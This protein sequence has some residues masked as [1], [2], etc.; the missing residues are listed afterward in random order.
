MNILFD[1]QAFEMQRFGGVSRSYAELI[2][3]LRK[4][5]CACKVGVKES[6]NVYLREKGLANVKSL[7]YTHDKWFEGKKWFKGQRTLTRQI[8]GA[9]GYYNDAVTMNMDYCV[10]LLKRQQ[11]DVFEPTFF[12]SYFLPYLKRK[13]FVLTVHDMIPELLGVDQP[14]AEEKRILCPLAAHIHVPSQN[15]KNDLIQILN[16]SSEKISVIPH[17]SPVVPPK[18]EPLFDFP[19]LLY[20]GARWSYKNFDQFANECSLIIAHYPKLRIVCTGEPFNEEELK[21]LSE[22]NLSE[23]VVNVPNA[24]E[25]KLQ[26]LYQFAAAFVYP[27][28]YEGFGIPILEA[29]VNGCPV[30]LNDASCFPEIGGNAAVYFDINRRGDLAEHIEVLLQSSEQDRAA[31]KANG[32]KRAKLFSWEESARKL[33]QIYDNIL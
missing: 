28:A 23:C 13:P 33:K 14:Q 5:G 32:L 30:L 21:M 20:V 31:L 29:F 27:S 7:Y 19:Y 12:N 3:H 2:A 8:M 17:G 18:R 1:Y 24:S 16:I 26:A 4:E 11:F 6:D 9:A 15:T 22:L 25:E 10:K